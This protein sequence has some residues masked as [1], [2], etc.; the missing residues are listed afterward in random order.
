VFQQSCT[1]LL[2]FNEYLVVEKFIIEKFKGLMCI[3]DKNSQQP[4]HP[5]ARNVFMDPSNFRQSSRMLVKS[6]KD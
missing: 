6:A 3:I 1:H 5:E 4:A 2:Y